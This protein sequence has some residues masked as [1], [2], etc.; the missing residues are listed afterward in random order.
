MLDLG[1]RTEGCGIPKR[2]NGFVSRNRRFEENWPVLDSGEIVEEKLE[3]IP[4][5]LQTN[6][7]KN[8][9]HNET[10]AGGNQ[11]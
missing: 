8:G 2:G 3:G 4:S 10:T 5:R 6:S 1:K 9:G 7:T 11:E